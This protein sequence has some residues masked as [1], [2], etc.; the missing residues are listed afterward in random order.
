MSANVKASLKLSLK[1]FL[2]LKS[3]LISKLTAELE[4]E[5]EMSSFT[6]DDE[7]SDIWETPVV[8]S[9]TVVKLSPIVEEL[10]G[11]KI[12]PEWIKCG[13]YESVE[14]AVEHL[15]KQIELD[16]ENK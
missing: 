6:A 5:K 3:E 8:D 11:K 4:Y 16:F 1:D 12:K 7:E 15:V 2:K 10:T 14:E 13:G 9:K